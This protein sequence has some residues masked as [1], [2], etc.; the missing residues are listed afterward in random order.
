M[1]GART[2]RRDAWPPRSFVAVDQGQGGSRFASELP[3]GKKAETTG[4]DPQHRNVGGRRLLGRPEQGAITANTHDQPRAVEIA[5]Q[6]ARA[7]FCGRAVGPDAKPAALQPPACL[8]DRRSADIDPRVAE[9]ADS[10][11]HGASNKAEN[12]GSPV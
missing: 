6:S 9:D 2:G 4:V 10:A 3:L 8:H 12:P 5:F 1:R 7:F 11:S